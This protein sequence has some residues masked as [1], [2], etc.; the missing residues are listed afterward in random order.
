VN[1]FVLITLIIFLL[2]PLF[3]EE[4]V[5]LS[6]GEWA[7]FLSEKMEGGGFAGEI[8]TAAFKEVGIRV[9]LCYY[10]W[11]RAEAMVKVGAVVGS[12]TWHM[13]EERKKYAIFSDP[14]G[15]SRY[16][17][18]YRKDLG[19][20]VTFKKLTD[21]KK[22]SIGGVASFWYK[23]FFKAAGIDMDTAASPE[24]NIKKLYYKRIALYP[25][26]E[27]VG[28]HLL[29]KMYPK[30]YMKFHTTE[31]SFKEDE[32]HIMFSKRHPKAEEIRK[33]FNIGLKAIRE[34]GI[35]NKIESKYLEKK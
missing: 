30:E 15:K 5:E 33:K 31:E 2:S 14:I 23:N 11:N 10:P 35:Y 3:A 16:V 28:W 24:I 26:D 1:R 19:E 34:N 22:Y 20:P 8:I 17:F 32:I 25:E 27:L 4:V 18:F 13:T 7:P 29:K 12:A 6:T 9:K 21:L